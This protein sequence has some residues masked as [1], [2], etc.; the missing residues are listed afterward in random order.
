MKKPGKKWIE[1][2]ANAGSLPEDASDQR[3]RKAVLVF[4]ASIYCIAGII[5]GIS[6]FALRLP[7]SGIIPLAYSFI[8]GLSLFYFFWTK[9]Y[10][11]FRFSQLSL[12]LLLPFLLQYSLGGFAASSTVMIW[13]ILSPVGALMFAG[14]TRALPWFLAYLVL[15]VLFG[16]LDP[17]LAQDPA[18][19]PSVFKVV[20]F[21]M[22]LGGVSTIFY[23]LLRYFVR[24]RELAMAVLD[25]EHRRVVE[26]KDRLDKIKRVMANFVPE[27]AKS[28]IEKDPEKGALD[29]YVKDATVLFLDIEGFTALLQKYSTE[30]INHVIESYFSI[31]YDLIQKN[32]G[33]VNEMAGDGMMVIFL[34]PDPI[35][36]AKS[37][38]R[39]ALEIQEQCKK[40]L[41]ER[42]S[43]L[44]PIQV[45]IGICSGEVY[46]GSTKM[47]GT[48][49]DRW[50]F[51]ASGPVTIV[52]A[53]LSDYAQG[54]QIL[55][56]EET[57]RSLENDFALKHLGKVQLKNFKEPFE[58]S[59]VTAQN[60]S[61]PSPF[62]A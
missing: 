30:R 26:E 49:G 17:K 8:S 50:T 51:T 56:G 20:F 48:G 40:Y 28:I 41:E 43:F 11:V 39:A 29:K 5:W 16:L 6:Y 37:A 42:D 22:N 10:G 31:F 33:D 9:R 4:L 2:M 1:R 57:V 46:L 53:R 58:V 36:R 59:Q 32:G 54:G 3:L 44:F 24:E 23:V 25:K 15:M 13:S 61:S 14:T 52:A 55:I 38:V 27:T 45:N 19:I 21:I 34:E 60:L 12:I 18:S 7:L 62:P 47:K 35:K